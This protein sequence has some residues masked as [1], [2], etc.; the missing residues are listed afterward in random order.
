ME[1]L[2][3]NGSGGEYFKIWIVNILLTIITLGLYYPWAKVRNKRYFYGN[4]E[5]NN[6]TFDYHATGKQLFISYLIAMGLFILY[7]IIQNISPTGSLVILA[8]F[9]LSFP[10]IIWK[11]LMFNMRVTSFSNVRFS[12][13]GSL[14]Q[15]YF[16]YLA[17]PILA[18]LSIYIMPILIGI[19]VGMQIVGES[20]AGVLFAIFGI[21][22]IP[23]ALYAFAVLKH[24]NTNYVM[25]SLHYGQGNFKTE[26]NTAKFFSILFKAFLI[27][28]FLTVVAFLLIGII[29]MLTGAGGDLMSIQNQ[30]NDPEA[31]QDIF[32]Q[33]IV[34]ALIAGLYL[35]FILVAVVSFSYVYARQRRYIFE[36]TKLD[37]KIGF[38]SSLRATPMAWVSVSNIFL[39]ICT[40][41][42]GIPWAKVRI[43]RLITENTHVDTSHGLSDYVTQQQEYQSSLG[44]QIGDAFDV[45]VGI[46]I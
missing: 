1:K 33:G 6:R 16:N 24:R 25:N 8:I 5:L 37:E 35:A 30:L 18:F 44:D 9:F 20:V 19:L 10:W 43:M 39:V 13:D 31:I 7:I 26:L 22:I 21:L 2:S 3:F 32:S 12:F 45:D 40:L 11:S 27:S 42:L 46:G 4:T 15:A 23:I 34:I 41:G 14:G 29:A 17:L 28:I 36:N 38:M